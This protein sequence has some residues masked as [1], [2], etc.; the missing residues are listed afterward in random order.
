MELE[1]AEAR[2]KALLGYWRQLQVCLSVVEA[3][4]ATFAIDRMTTPEH[5][6]VGLTPDGGGGYFSNTTQ[7]YGFTP[8]RPHYRDL[9]NGSRARSMSCHGRIRRR[10]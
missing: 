7:H 6:L 8:D 9:T 5:W 1:A 10:L 3:P 4:V 2:E